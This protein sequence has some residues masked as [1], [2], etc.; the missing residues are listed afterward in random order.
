MSN[1]YC[2]CEQCGKNTG[3]DA[4]IAVCFACSN[5]D[6]DDWNSEE[7]KAYRKAAAANMGRSKSPAK[8]EAARVNG[9]KGG[10]PK[11]TINCFTLKKDG[12][13][14][15]GINGVL[16]GIARNTAGSISEPAHYVVEEF[17]YKGF[18]SSAIPAM[19]LLE[20]PNTN[21]VISGES[22]TFSQDF[23]PVTLMSITA[24]TVIK[25]KDSLSLEANTVWAYKW[26]GSK[27]SKQKID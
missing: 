18:A 21:L 13:V 12:T 15:K 6:E 19:L 14:V 26:D 7:A 22:T 8:V 20:F 16:S 10:R 24:D 4:N 25:L 1:Q 17:N 9:A 11:A 3:I 27:L 5:K 2:I 23:A